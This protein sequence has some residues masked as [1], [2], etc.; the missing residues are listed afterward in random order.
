MVAAASQLM[1]YRRS[2]EFVVARRK[3]RLVKE[4]LLSSEAIVERGLS[5]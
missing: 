1:V 2:G 4:S 3:L 5:T